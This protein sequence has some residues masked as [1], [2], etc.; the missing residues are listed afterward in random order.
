MPGSEQVAALLIDIEAELR[1][2]NLWD[3]VSPSEQALA[4]SE[5]FCVDTLSFTQ[6]L[7]FIFLPTMYHLMESEAPL[8]TECGIAPMAEEHFRGLFTQRQA[9]ANPGGAGPVALALAL[10]R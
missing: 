2:L 8:P 10:L 4:S 3:D 9:R 5:P 7:Q 1:Q 6:W